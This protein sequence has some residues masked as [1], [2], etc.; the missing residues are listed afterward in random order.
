M[1]EHFTGPI[2]PEDFLADFLPT[3]TNE[4]RANFAKM[5]AAIE[6]L[7]ATVKQKKKVFRKSAWVARLVNRGFVSYAGLLL[8]K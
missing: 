2:V 1:S 4:A 7:T 6:E 5:G 8:T 3:T